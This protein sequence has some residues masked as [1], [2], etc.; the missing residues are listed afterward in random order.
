[1]VALSGVLPG[2]TPPKTAFLRKA[3]AWAGGVE[4][5]GVAQELDDVVE[6]GE[7]FVADRLR[8]LNEPSSISDLNLDPAL[9]CALEVDR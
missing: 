4:L 8:V 7:D 2:H 9:S 1:M 5:V 6:F 3:R